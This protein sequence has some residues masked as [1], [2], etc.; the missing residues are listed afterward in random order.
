MTA[1]AVDVGLLMKART[2]AQRSADAGAHGGAVELMLRPGDKDRSA[3]V[4]E[5]R[6]MALENEIMGVSSHEVDVHVD[7]Q[8]DS[9]RTIVYRTAA[10]NNPV[11]TLFAAILGFEDVDVAADATAEAVPA[12]GAHCPIPVMA[13]DRWTDTDGDNLYDSGEPYSSCARGEPCTGYSEED[14][15]TVMEIKSQNTSSGASATRTCGAENPEWYCWVD[16]Q[17]GKGDVD[18]EELEDILL[19]ECAN[20][21]FDVSRGGQLESSPGNKMSVVQSVKQFID[22]NGG[23]SLSWNGTCVFNSSTGDCAKSS[24]PR[25]RSMPITD[26]TTIS[27][28]G[29]GAHAGVNNF[30]PIFIEKVADSFDE[31]HGH[32]PAGQWNLYVRLIDGAVDGVGTGGQEDQLLKTVVITE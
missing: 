17:V 15:G 10:R 23:S 13:V 31:P 6:D 4:R 12:G 28:S 14:V 9:V 11:A 22:A 27:N 1:L 19:H 7:T 3:A 5:A 8:G 20:T 30:A 32:G 16:N 2:D 21:E 26:P 29:E 18:T 24:H 25:L